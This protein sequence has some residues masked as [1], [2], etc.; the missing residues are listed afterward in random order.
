MDGLS[1]KL[2]LKNKCKTENHCFKI[3]DIHPCEEQFKN[4]KLSRKIQYYKFGM[5]I[6][7]YQTVTD[8]IENFF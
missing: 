3:I 2:I 8:S 1:A 7:E 6:D 5:L 4:F